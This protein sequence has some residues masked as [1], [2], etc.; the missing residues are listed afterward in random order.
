MDTLDRDPTGNTKAE[1]VIQGE[2]FDEEYVKQN[3]LRFF[4][5]AEVEAINHL[6]SALMHRTVS[7]EAQNQCMAF[8]ESLGCVGFGCIQK[9]ETLTELRNTMT[10]EEFYVFVLEQEYEWW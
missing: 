2:R 10:A 9:Q 3:I 7:G 4:E 6:R 8:L 1:H 5:G